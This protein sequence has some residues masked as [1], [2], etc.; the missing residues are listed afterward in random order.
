[1]YTLIVRTISGLERLRFDGTFTPFQCE[2]DIKDLK[3]FLNRYDIQFVECAIQ[4]G[5]VIWRNDILIQLELF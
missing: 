4:D 5:V 3:E 2:E 1:M